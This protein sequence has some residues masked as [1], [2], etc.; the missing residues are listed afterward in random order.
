[1]SGVPTPEINAT[2]NSLH[3][4]I[5][6]RA[7]L[8]AATALTTAIRAAAALVTLEFHGTLHA[9]LITP[10]FYEHCPFCS[11]LPSWQVWAAQGAR[12][13]Q[14]IR[15]VGSDIREGQTVLGRGERVGPAEVGL[16]ATIGAARIQA[17]APHHCKEEFS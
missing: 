2:L 6:M 3:I 4:I 13:G 5:K 8:I 10:M 12:P 11:K 1:M 17:R 7:R 16:L 14:D 15:A 9:S